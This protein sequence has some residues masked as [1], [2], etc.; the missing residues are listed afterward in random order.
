MK[1]IKNPLEKLLCPPGNGVFTIHTAKDKKLAYQKALYKSDDPDVI[2]EKWQASLKNLN[3]QTRAILLGICADTGGGI[4]RGANWGPLFLRQNLQELNLKNFFDI[5]DIRVI[6]HLLHDKYLNTKTI[7]ECRAAL[8][9]KSTM[10]LPVSPLSIAESVYQNILK[11]KPDAKIFML[12]G[13]HSVSYPAVKTILKHHK[14]LK[15]NVAVIHFDAH[16]DLLEKRLGIDICFG[17]WAYHIIPFL[18]SP[19]QLIQ[20]GIRASRLERGH[21]EKKLKVSQFWAKDLNYETLDGVLNTIIKSLK[22]NGTTHL[23]LSFD[24]DALDSTYASAT[25]TPEKAGLSPDLCARIIQGLGEEFPYIGADLV[26]VAPMVRAEINV[27]PEP[28]NTLLSAGMICKVILEQL[29]KTS[30]PS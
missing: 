15:H 8:Y 12:G 22:K 2:Q 1:E 19:T 27:N 4:M 14:K 13:D 6:P 25:G 9:G 30:C 23:Y 29:E 28:D 21:W 17:S 18:K 16:T 3:K 11:Q 26:E 7:K 5:G 24:I 10:A 20:L